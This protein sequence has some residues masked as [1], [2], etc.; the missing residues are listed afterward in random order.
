V[1]F[2]NAR[3][4]GKYF[5]D[6]IANDVRKSLTTVFGNT[7]MKAFLLLKGHFNEE[8]NKKGGVRWYIEF[9]RVAQINRMGLLVIVASVQDV[10]NRNVPPATSNSLIKEVLANKATL[11]ELSL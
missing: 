8:A 3:R 9:E 11:A 6:S 5:A 2:P 1:P 4:E 10:L 7:C